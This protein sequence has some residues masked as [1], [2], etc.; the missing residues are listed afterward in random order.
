MQDA[1]G[2]HQALQR[3]VSDNLNKRYSTTDDVC[4][5]IW[6][7]HAATF[8]LYQSLYEER[9][10]TE[11]EYKEGQKKISEMIQAQQTTSNKPAVVPA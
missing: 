5:A 9:C 1:N 3:I 4:N 8:A 6:A 2:I 7:I 11:E 10:I